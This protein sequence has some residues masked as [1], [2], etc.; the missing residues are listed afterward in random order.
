MDRRLPG[1]IA[2]LLLAAGL[3]A[4][5]AGPLRTGFLNDDYLFLEEARTR[6]VA[7]SLTRLGALG[8]YYRPLS[9]QL[10]FE[11]LTPLAGERPAV[12]HGVN[13]ALHLAA[14]A[15]LF[16]LL[17]ALAPAPA[18]LAGLLWFALLPFQRVN[19]TWISCSQD[20][21]AL[22]L[23]LG[24]LALHRR[25]RAAGAAACAL[26]AFASKESALPLAAGL[27]AWDVAIERRA[28]GAAL[29][30][31]GPTLA[32]T[33]AW[34]AVLLA[35]RAAHPGAAAFVR[36]A[37]GDF[38]AGYLH[39][40]QSLLGLD[41][42]PGF[43]GGLLSRGPDPW[44]LVALALLAAWIPAAARG[45]RPADPR[46]GAAGATA[47]IR[48][49]GAGARA[50]PAPPAGAG[51]GPFPAP[52]A[53][54]VF[55]VAWLAAFGLVTG[56][57]AYA[58][59]SYYYTLF[60]V[61]G[62]A[63]AAVAAAR[64]GLDRVRWLVLAAALLWWHAGANAPRA[65]AVAGSPWVWT[66]HLT[67]A[68]FERAAALT[69]TLA[70]QLRAL[71]PAPPRGTRFFFATL[72]PYAGFQMGNGALIR[73]LYR[74]PTLESHFYSRYSAATAGDHPARFLY[75]N[76]AALEPLYGARTPDPMFQVGTDLLLLDRP[77]GAA[78]A[79]RRGLADGE[80]P[81]DH[82]YWL[83]W[84]ELWS[85]RREAAERAWAEWGAR[86]D[87]LAWHAT[88]RRAQTL[89]LLAPGD[90]VGM[91]R[92]LLEAIRLGIG[93]PEGHATLG[94]V[95]RQRRPKYGVLELKVAA[96]LDP[97]DAATRR[98]LV[99]GL[100]A[101]RLDDAARRELARYRERVAAA[102]ADPEIAAVARAL[103]SGGAGRGVVEF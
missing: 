93:R 102:D 79:F 6:P 41:H 61:G 84:A 49:A 73:A 56:P 17:R 71:E 14:L 1:W 55:A 22:A 65:F 76:G 87:S 69:R 32:A 70:E 94:L 20:L 23:A 97:R 100:A 19:L 90:S 11:A 31:A 54:A 75:W 99:L 77:E 37:P 38:V 58:W 63:L 16:D 2:A 39:G 57:V 21:L 95:L 45:R 88:L 35:M 29:R 80:S 60:A 33:A 59:S 91:Q 24:A 5:H 47:P 36:W 8:N 74:D 86:D 62:A 96:W 26:L 15:L 44:A 4:L 67:S 68:Y 81:L 25:G 64:L 12:F 46:P 66:S 42:P 103:A 72:P 7:E 53:V 89:R 30:R 27:V 98:D 52:P 43:L 50:I 28:W 34:G 3:A 83:G 51:T 10:Y 13:F 40:V 18:A 9:R 85:G 82:L 78:A 92:L 48:P 101:A